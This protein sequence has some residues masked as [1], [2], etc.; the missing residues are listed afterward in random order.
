MKMNKEKTVVATGIMV[1]NW[2]VEEA[3]FPASEDPR[4]CSAAYAD[5][6]AAI[7]LWDHVCYPYNANS[8][9]ANGGK[10][11]L[12][13]FLIPIDDQDEEGYKK[14]VEEFYQDPHIFETQYWR[15]WV[16]PNWTNEIVGVGALRYMALSAKHNCDYL[17][18]SQRQEYLKSYLSQK[19]FSDLLGHLTAQQ[20]IDASIADYIIEVAR[21]F[22][23]DDGFFIE[24]PAFA[25]Y[26]I[27]HTP[28][29]MTPVEYAFHL[30]EY[31]SVRHYRNYL[32]KFT[33]AAAEANV[34]ELGYLKAMAK[35][36]IAEVFA[37][38]GNDLLSKPTQILPNFVL[39]T[40]PLGVLE[41]VLAIKK[42]LQEADKKMHLVFLKELTSHTAK[43]FQRA[44][45]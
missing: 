40:D 30:R 28:P 3:I 41:N 42:T 1:D 44:N 8:V 29:E 25:R 31:N 9:W 14:A 7:V 11:P 16:L 27:D 39:P 10:H 4:H 12:A 32:Q 37:E 21:P 2:F 24:M 45:S 20:F 23:S 15:K 17:P 13:N 6:L 35:D 18:S 36:A 19:G 33:S 22:I 26:I 38:V 43:A 34:L 5:L